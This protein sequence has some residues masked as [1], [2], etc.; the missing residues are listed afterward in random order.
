MALPVALLLA[1][2]GPARA[3][4]A[5]P[6]A[7]KPPAQ[8]VTKPPA[9]DATKPPALDALVGAA[10]ARNP[11]RAV[12]RGAA[13]EGQRTT[14]S[15]E[16]LRTL[17]GTLGDPFRVVGLL[18]GVATPLPVLPIFVIR[19]ASPGM[20]GF[21]LDGMRV[22][23]L[24]H[25]LVGGGVVHSRFV[26][27]LSFYPGAY[28]VA[29]GHYAGGVIDAH[30]RPAREQGVHGEGE[31][32][33]F[34][35]SA[36]VEAALPRGVRVTA[37]GHYGYPGPLVH[38]I[39]ERVALSYWDYQARL[40]YR[41]FTAQVLG[42]FDSL[43]IQLPRVVNGELVQVPNTYQ[44]AF[45]RLQLRHTLRRGRLHGEAALHGGFD[46]MTIFQGYGVRK[47]SLGL[48][49]SL[50]Y[51]HRLFQVQAGVDSELSRFTPANF[52]DDTVRAR[53][54]DLGE[55]GAPRDGVTAG[56]Y[57]RLTLELG[58]LGI[59]AGGRADV[60]HAGQ[61]TLLGLEPRLQLRLLATPWL[62]FHGGVG[63]YQQ[64]PSFPVPLPGIDTFALR[65]GLQRAL[66]A[67]LG[68]ELTL[69]F[70]LTLGATGFYQRFQNS[71][72]VVLDLAPLVCTSPPP[73]SLTGY[74]ARV[75]RQVDGA[76]FGMELMLR[77][78]AGLFTGWLA[79]TL[80]RSE[81]AFAC[82]LAPADY[83]QTHVLNAVVQVR[84]P[85]R[86][87]VGGRLFMQSGRPFTRLEF[88]DGTA[89]VRNAE[90]LPT[91]VQLDLRVDREW[92]FRRFAVAVFIEAANVTYGEAI[93]G[94][95]YPVIPIRDETGKIT[96][97]ITRYDMPQNNG[98]R[99]ILPSL[100]VRG[101]F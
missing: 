12:I 2:P 9:Q 50:S 16:E 87:M 82:G 3:Q 58:P 46:D 61:V 30:T 78:K 85:W 51:R 53:P 35:V 96:S 83:D 57:A 19:G 18:P 17:P 68:Q 7:T 20:N 81:R 55:L 94:V 43:T 23:Q 79:Y 90:R 28:D 29:F 27:E 74:L 69:P 92:L 72:D 99:W 15:G 89:T 5:T 45:H 41:G 62:R 80:S 33:I 56:A 76:S 91:T 93:F 1:A 6:A 14:V 48:R 71:N 64:P 97:S 36:A 42:S 65:L 101:R 13:H 100:G 73:E 8:D 4:D 25:L 49:G 66:H 31:L 21:F 39:D 22:P 40:D 26:D 60:Y 24:F 84:L 88:P 77:R 10:A 38:A 98:F 70:G 54:D 86:L 47:L 63:L 95:T 52:G 11:Y 75:T 67:A 34:D 59:T 32:R 37:S 44:V